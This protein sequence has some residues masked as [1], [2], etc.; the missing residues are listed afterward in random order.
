MAAVMAPCMSQSVAAVTRAAKVLALKPCSAWST[1]A[2][3]S[4]RVERFVRLRAGQHEEEI[5][6]DGEFGL[7]LDGLLALAQAMEIGDDG[8]KLSRE[9]D[10]LAA[11]GGGIIAVQVGVDAAERTDG[12]AKRVHRLGFGWQCFEDR[13]G[14][15]GKGDV[16]GKIGFKL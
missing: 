12:G 9:P 14:V 2:A 8:R 7:G 6:G 15:G 10:G 4:T 1:R 3:S 13:R 5:G 11:I 16:G